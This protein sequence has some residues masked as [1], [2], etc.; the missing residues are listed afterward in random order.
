MRYYD[1]VIGSLRRGGFTI[2]LAAHAFAVIDAFVYGFMLQE[3]SMPIQTREDLAGVADT[4][5]Q[6]LPVDEYPHF[7]EMILDHAL[8]PGYSYGDE[9]EFGLDLILDAFEQRISEA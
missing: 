6:A 7:A 4:I 3:L 1:A 9:F 2:E 8:Q 5:L